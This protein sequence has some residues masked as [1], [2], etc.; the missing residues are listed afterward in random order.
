MAG[1]MIFSSLLFFGIDEVK[2]KGMF[3]GIIKKENAEE[4]FVPPFDYEN[5]FQL[6][7]AAG[8]S[9]IM[10]SALE[11]DFS[12]IGESGADGKPV[13]VDFTRS[14]EIMKTEV[15]QSFWVSV[16]NNNPSRCKSKDYCE[17][18]HEV[19]HVNGLTVEMCPN[20]P[21]E[22]VSWHDVQ[23]FIEKLNVQL[24]WVNCQGMP[25]DPPG[26]L[27]LPTEAEWEFAARGGTTTAYYFGD[28]PTS[29]LLD[30]HTWNFSNSAD[31]THPV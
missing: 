12:N 28:N 25:K 9:F 2:G 3:E 18:D 17:D 4:V 5:G 15:T 26:C 30:Q 7:E 14:F 8:R 13:E 27:R 24:G 21:V 20:N 10:G 11:G 19:V 1:L 31:Q 6:I 16:M 22:S 29:D 23:E